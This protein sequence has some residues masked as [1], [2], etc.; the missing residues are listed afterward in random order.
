MDFDFD[1]FNFAYCWNIVG[2]H[3]PSGPDDIEF[4]LAKK[5]PDENLRTGFNVCVYK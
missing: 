2:P 3:P 5:N 4:L 1:Y